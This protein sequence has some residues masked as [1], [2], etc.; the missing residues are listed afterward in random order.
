MVTQHEGDREQKRGPT[1]TP[2]FNSFPFEHG[3]RAKEASVP[4]GKIMA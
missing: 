2:T 3:Q 1:V 4:Q